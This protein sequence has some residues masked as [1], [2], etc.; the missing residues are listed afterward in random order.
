MA[1]QSGNMVALQSAIDSPASDGGAGASHK[2]RLA[3]MGVGGTLMLAAAAGSASTPADPNGKATVGPAKFTALAYTGAPVNRAWGSFIIDLTGIEVPTDG[4]RKPLLLEHG[5][6]SEWPN[7]GFIDQFSI[8]KDGLRI[9]GSLLSNET[10]EKV[11]MDAADGFPWEASIGPDP[12]EVQMLAQGMESTVNGRTVV[13]P[14]AIVTRS[15]LR[16]TS[17]CV[18]GADPDTETEI[19]AMRLSALGAAFG[20]T[21]MSDKNKTVDPATLTIDALRLANPGLVEQIV[22]SAAPAAATIEQIEAIPGTTDTLTLKLAKEKATE[23]V[24]VRAVCADLKLRLDGITEAHKAEVNKLT[25]ERDE[26]KGKLALAAKS[27]GAD[28][29]NLGLPAAA[30]GGAAQTLALSG[31]DPDKD[32]DASEA[33]RN[34]FGGKKGAFLK[35]ARMQ[36]A[37]GESYLAGVQGA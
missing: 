32:W 2:L 10:A 35:F 37:D 26:L 28:P 3:G 20:G 16:E 34:K 7:I 15:R 24:A 13:G 8:D 29:V 9:S 23:V 19:T 1:K 17:L 6:T 31:T 11:R 4:S 33:L 36:L 25:A 22:A 18:L 12:I 21:S 27:A 5:Y 30:S 14:M